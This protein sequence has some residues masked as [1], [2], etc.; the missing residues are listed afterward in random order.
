MGKRVCEGERE[1]EGEGEREGETD[2]SSSRSN[3]SVPS[4][5][6]AISLLKVMTGPFHPLLTSQV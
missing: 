4:Q 3:I 6:S 2:S 1:G 5:F